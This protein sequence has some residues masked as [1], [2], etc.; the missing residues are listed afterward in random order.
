VRRDIYKRKWVESNKDRIKK[1]V[2]DNKDRIK[3]VK[4]KWVKN[5]PDKVRVS[6]LKY[7]K[8]NP[9]RVKESYN[10]SVRKRKIND[11]S[12]KLACNI[13]SMVSKT[14]RKGG[15]IKTSKTHEILG[16][17]FDEFKMHLGSQFEPWMNWGNYGL[18]NGE[19]CYGWDIDH[20]I[21]LATII[22]E[23][24]IIR[25]NHHTNLQPLCSYV[26]RIVKRGK[27][28]AE[29]SIDF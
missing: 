9:E 7:K 4:E 23:D 11:P 28:N 10:K 25:L 12:F 18:Y 6:K 8:N 21:P 20:I 22:T 3:A 14:I 19:E 5:N 17:S 27:I 2:E 13:R 16:C 24:D 15:Y 26:N 29:L 1:Y